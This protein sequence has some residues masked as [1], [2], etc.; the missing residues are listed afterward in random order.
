MID[1]FFTA[2]YTYPHKK[3]TIL[4]SPRQLKIFEAMSIK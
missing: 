1:R 4:E 2:K 3:P